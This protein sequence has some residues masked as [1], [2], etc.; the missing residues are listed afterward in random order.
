MKVL[1]AGA[2][3]L[4]GQQL[5]QRLMGDSDVSEI[6]VLSRRPLE[7]TSPKIRLHLAEL[8]PRWLDSLQGLRFDAVYCCLGTTMK[9]AGSQ[10]AFRR[11]DQEAVIQLARFAKESGSGFFG[12]ISSVGAD[13]RSR[14][15]YL[16]VK[17]ETEDAVRALK[18]PSLAILNPSVLLGKRQAFRLAD[19]IGGR[20]MRVLNPLLVGSLRKYRGVEAREVARELWARS[21]NEKK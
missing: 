2:T 14:N 6:H 11:V 1:I 21:K 16:R 10:E 15:F 20:A 17:G 18:L 3:G 5:L 4:V 9:V 19:A 7:L 13:S 12:M 8:G